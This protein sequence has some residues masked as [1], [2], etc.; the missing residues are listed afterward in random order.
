MRRPL[1]YRYATTALAGALLGLVML[2]LL[3]LPVTTSEPERSAAPVRLPTIAKVARPTAPSFDIVRATAEGSLVIAGRANPNATVTVLDGDRPLGAARADRHGEWVVV[4]DKSL[5][6]GSH[7]LYLVAETA[8]GFRERNDQPVTLLI[9][10]RPGL[11]PVT[12]NLRNGPVI[13]TAATQLGPTGLF[14]M[15]RGP[16][17][18]DLVI[19]VDGMPVGEAV[20]DEQGRWRLAVRIALRNGRHTLRADQVSDG[21]V[22]ATGNAIL[23]VGMPKLVSTDPRLDEVIEFENGVPIL[24]EGGGRRLSGHAPGRGPT[25]RHY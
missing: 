22:L 11:A 14:L 9:P 4:P 5:P 19:H 6:P 8:D 16:A 25:I 10:A 23:E 21:V 1:F 12:L 17:D 7:A 2:R 3:P 18:A 13:I 15:G 24:V 20:P